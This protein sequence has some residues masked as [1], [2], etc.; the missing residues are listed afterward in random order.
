MRPSSR[1]DSVDDISIFDAMEKVQ[2]DLDDLSDF[3][4]ENPKGGQTSA[5]WFLSENR[6]QNVREHYLSSFYKYLG[7]ADGGVS[8]EAQSVQTVRCVQVIIEDLDPKGDDLQCLVRNR[9]MDIRDHFCEPMLRKKKLTGNTL[10]SYIRSL[11]SFCGLV[12]TKLAD[13]CLPEYTQE[14]LVHLLD[15]LPKDRGTIHRRTSVDTTTRMVNEAYSQLTKENLQEFEKSQCVKDVIKLDG[16]KLTLNEFTLV[17][18]FLIVPLLSENGSRPG[19]LENATLQHFARAREHP[20]NH[21]WAFIVDK[22]KTMRHQG[23]PEFCMD[24]RIYSYLKVYVKFIR[25]QFVATEDV[26]TTFTT[27]EGTSFETGTTGKRATEF[28]KRADVRPD[29]RVSATRICKFHSGQAIAL[30]PKEK[31]LINAHMKCTARTAVT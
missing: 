29:I 15:R 1:D 22:H 7:H 6:N 28:F 5:Q 26:T 30:D 13:Q 19:P 8:S 2:A 16:A 18:D 9:S 23:P 10:K 21:T 4:E 17:R 12:K 25:S 3:V 31:R 24:A 27:T 11:E 14:C 20:R